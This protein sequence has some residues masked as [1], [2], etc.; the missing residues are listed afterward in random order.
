MSLGSIGV[1][2]R[3]TQ[4]LSARTQVF[5][6][7]DR[8]CRRRGWETERSLASH[9]LFRIGISLSP[10]LLCIDVVL[11]LSINREAAVSSI[12]TLPAS[13][14]IGSS[15]RPARQGRWLMRRTS[16]GGWL[17]HLTAK[18]Q[19]KWIWHPKFEA[20]AKKT[21]QK[22]AGY[23]KAPVVVFFCPA[24]GGVGIR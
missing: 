9:F 23:V 24:Y 14:S 10:C 17:S 5:G 21:I 7:Q 19:K 18:R 8:L 6:Y 13:V 22:R 16:R 20:E 15:D 4:S 2:L 3:R 12:L 1:C 11:L